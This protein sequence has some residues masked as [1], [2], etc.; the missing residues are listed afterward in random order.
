MFSE[1]KE[2]TSE[3]QGDISGRTPRYPRLIRNRKEEHGLFPE[4]AR[5][6]GWKSFWWDEIFAGD[7]ND[8]SDVTLPTFREQERRLKGFRSLFDKAGRP[9]K[10]RK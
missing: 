4:M 6:P 10:L 7:A 1:L 9:P 2:N 5:E 3:T 8:V